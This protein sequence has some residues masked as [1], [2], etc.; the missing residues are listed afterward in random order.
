MS[1]ATPF[2]DLLQHG[3]HREYKAL[4]ILGT[5]GLHW[6]GKRWKAHHSNHLK[7]D[8]TLEKMQWSWEGWTTEPNVALKKVTFIGAKGH[9]EDTVFK[10]WTHFV[11]MRINCP[12]SCS[13]LYTQELPPKNIKKSTDDLTG[14]SLN[15]QRTKWFPFLPSL[16]QWW[17][18][19]A[20][21]VCYFYVDTKADR[22]HIKVMCNFPCKWFQTNKSCALWLS[23]NWLFALNIYDKMFRI[24]I[25]AIQSMR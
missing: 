9:L 5:L 24:N 12:W 7:L 16:V 3:C 18:H 23:G 2:S 1:S 25:L 10:F 19:H 22:K 17:C 4:W 6:P 13:W 11:G 21:V 15:L 14:N 8:T 20:S